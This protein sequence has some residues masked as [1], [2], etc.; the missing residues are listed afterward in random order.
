MIMGGHMDRAL[1][2]MLISLVSGEVYDVSD[3]W[4]TGGILLVEGLTLNKGRRSTIVY[5][6]RIE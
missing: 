3:G 5:M 4:T 6:N 2:E 1:G